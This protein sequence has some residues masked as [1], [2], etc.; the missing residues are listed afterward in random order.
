[1]TPWCEIP[2][3]KQLFTQKEIEDR[4]KWLLLGI[5]ITLLHI[6]S[7]GISPEVS[8]SI[9]DKK[10]WIF[11]RTDSGWTW[12]WVGDIITIW[13]KTYI[14][15]A[16]HVVSHRWVQDIQVLNFSGEA[17]KTGKILAH[18]RLD[19]AFIEVLS[20]KVP[21][22]DIS[23]KYTYGEKS[24]TVWLW[25]NH[26]PHVTVEKNELSIQKKALDAITRKN[27][28]NQIPSFLVTVPNGV[29]PGDS[30]S[31]V[32]DELGNPKYMLLKWETITKSIGHAIPIEYIL[33]AFAEI[34]T[35]CK[36]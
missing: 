16:K 32:V 36:P 30:G 24:I 6:Q 10:V 29:K 23:K 11:V 14:S 3:E 34:Q 2:S 5:D 26:R 17:V 33:K 28:F 25:E 18:P 8:Q 22:Y 4:K 13:E 20:N 31:M 9:V 21:G 19:V 35:E 27:P 12:A 1:M 7:E 15:T